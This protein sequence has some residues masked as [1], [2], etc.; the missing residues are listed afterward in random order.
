M[1]LSGRQPPRRGA[2]LLKLG[3]TLA[4][5]PILAAQPDWLVESPHFRV[6]AR[7]YPGLE[8]EAVASAAGFLE[9]IRALFVREGL[10][11]AR[12]ADGPLDILLLP[13]TLQLHALLR[14]PPP[15]GV[16]G[17]NVRGLDRN[18]VL[19][20]WHARPGPWVTLA[21][22]YAHQLEDPDWPLWFR[23]G[24]AVYLARLT[25]PPFDAPLEADLLPALERSPWLAWPEL[26]AAEERGHAARPELFEAQSWLLVHWLARQQGR[27]ANLAPEAADRSLSELGSAGLDET[28]K[29]YA[30]QLRPPAPAGA[31]PEDL[32]ETLKRHATQLRQHARGVVGTAVPA[33]TVP[34]ASRA[35]RWEIPLFEAEV[36]RNLQDVGSAESRLSLLVRDFPRAA[37]VR[38]AYAAVQLMRGKQD[39]AERHY[40]LALALGDTRAQT[41]YRYA[42]LKMR[43]GAD[44]AKRAAEAVRFARRAR[45]AMPWEPTHQL[46]LTQARMLQGDWAGAFD[47]LHQLARFPGWERR[48]E[49]EVLEIRRRQHQAFAALPPPA[50]APAVPASRVDVPT[51]SE[52]P[53]WTAPRRRSSRSPI[54][55]RWP[56]AGT[57][58][59][60]GRIAWIDCTDG[61]RRI[62]LHSPFQRLVLRENPDRSPRLI[63]RPF[64]GKTLPCA[65]RGWVV[66][67][68]Y[69]KLPSGGPVDGEA[70]AIRF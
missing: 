43:P 8:A 44:P 12:R 67:V 66:A 54:S 53:S 52:L 41:A 56:P 14:E 28:L 19:V 18:L 9:T 2:V 35:A 7:E 17:V 20:A 34:D 15:S 16:R 25:Q 60:Y 6:L 57:W 48:V 70:V 10:G 21:H 27:I 13:D 32:G 11:A 38:S 64:K 39:L 33:G 46:A 1:T 50:L 49:R 51:P 62:V 55:V 59:A 36:D 68:A 29:R 69:R 24:R 58:L 22:E 45:D 63:N 65:S 37:R 3:G 47:E 31:G 5:L 40:G 26:L 4:L 30:A 61:D 42:L 23:E